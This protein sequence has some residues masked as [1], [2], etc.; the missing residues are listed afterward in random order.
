MSTLFLVSNDRNL[1]IQN[2][3]LNGGDNQ[4]IAQITEPRNIKSG[5]KYI[6]L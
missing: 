1:Y 3:V 5:V 4:P 6:F 2:K